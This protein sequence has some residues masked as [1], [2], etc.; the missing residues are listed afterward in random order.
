[1]R[2]RARSGSDTMAAILPMLFDPKNIL[3]A[4]QV[5][6]PT[7]FAH[8]TFHLNGLGFFHQLLENGRA[9]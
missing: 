8:S 4:L 5:H 2:R 9:H 6:S 3:T 7:A 1:M